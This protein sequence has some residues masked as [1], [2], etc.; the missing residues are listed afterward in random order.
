[1]G[2]TPQHLIIWVQKKACNLGTLCNAKISDQ[3]VEVHEYCKEYY[4]L[5]C[6]DIQPY[7]SGVDI[8]LNLAEFLNICYRNVK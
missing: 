6:F 5:K 8:Y 3:G 1:M 7:S 4:L 2:I